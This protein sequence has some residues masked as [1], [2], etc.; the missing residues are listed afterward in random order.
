MTQL[1]L[2][3]GEG[4]SLSPQYAEGR[5]PSDYIRIIADEGKAL[6]DGER[7]T[8][9]VDIKLSELNKWYEIETPQEEEEIPDSEALSIIMGEN[10]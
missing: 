10:V 6:S 1:T 3:K 5:V 2:Y 8:D 4:I 9:C 7:I